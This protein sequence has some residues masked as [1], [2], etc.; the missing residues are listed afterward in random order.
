ME[1]KLFIIPMLVICLLF[2]LNSVSMAQFGSVFVEYNQNENNNDNGFKIGGNRGFDNKWQVYWAH[3]FTEK[4]DSYIGLGYTLFKNIYLETQYETNRDV[5]ETYLKIAL[6]QPLNKVLSYYGEVIYTD[7]HAKLWD[8]SNELK[9]NNGLQWQI[10]PK[11]SISSY[12]YWIDKDVDNDK[13][14]CNS[15]EFGRSIGFSSQPFKR[16]NVWGLY[17][18]IDIDYQDQTVNPGEKIHE[19]VCGVTYNINKYN[20]YLTYDTDTE[21]V[22]KFGSTLQKDGSFTLGVSYSFF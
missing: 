3:K 10:N 2:I 21:R 4:D 12:A 17:R 15:S 20:I 5:D 1:K 18:L 6:N 11:L 7:Y 8:N 9:F 22:T 14:N 19:L 13:V 16:L